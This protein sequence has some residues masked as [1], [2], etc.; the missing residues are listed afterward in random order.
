MVASAKVFGVERGPVQGIAPGAWVSVYKVCGAQGCFSSDTAAA[1]EQAIKDGV[2]VINFSI[3]G[4]TSPF[5]DPTELAFLDAY[6]A[7]VFVSASGGNDGP[8]VSTVNHLAPWVTTV[9]ASTQKREFDSTL[10]LTSGADSKVLVGAS[11]TDGVSTATPVVMSSAAPYNHQLCDAPAPPGKI[12]ACARGVNARVDK[13]FNVK[14]GGAVGMIL[15]NPTLADVETD[16]HWLPAV[17]LA[18]GTQFLAFISA[19]PAG[20]TATF[21]AGAKADGQADVLAA[22]S[23]RGPAGLFIKPDVTA[24][25]VEILAGNTPTPE[26]SEL[27][28]PGEY[29]MAIAGTSMAS[30]HIAGSGVLLKAL[31]PDWTPGQIKSALM[32]TAVTSVV[33]E[34]LTTAADPFDIG[35]GR[36]NLTVA[37]NPGLTFDETAENLAAI[38]ANPLK[39]V[40]ANLPSINAPVLPGTLTTSR[41]VKN[42]T[43][44][45]QTYKVSAKAPAGSTITVSPSSFTVAPGKTAKFSVTIKSLSPTAEQQFGEVR[46][47]PSRSGLPALHLPV[48]FVPQQGDVSLTSSCTP[49]SIK[50]LKN[51]TCSVTAANKSAL[52]T[53]VNLRTDTGLRTPITSASGADVSGLFTAKKDNVALSG[54]HPGIPSVAAGVS[55]GYLPLDL[56]GITP[57][58]IGDEQIL[59]FNIPAFSYNGRSYGTIGVDSNGYVVVGGGTAADNECCNLP[60]GASPDLPNNILAPFWTDLDGTGAPGIF[61]ASLTDGVNT[62]IVVEWRVNVF[63]TN[64]LQTFQLWLG[65]NGTQDV[66]YTYDP[67]NLP[68]A[69]GQPFLVVAENEVGQGGA[70]AGAPTEDLVVTSTP[71]SVGGTY[72]YTVKLLGLLPGTADVT[73]SMTTPIVRGTTV[74]KTPVT[75]TLK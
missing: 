24:P 59:N 38:E 46:L 36:V 35:S 2:K 11:I 30:P 20:V 40:D 64:S 69:G 47:T 14:A 57:Q 68:A 70:L 28:P 12:V 33:K 37:G 43:N 22:F 44:A 75:V 31:H 66:A 67:G 8:A 27:G 73:T 32:T 13:G 50:I 3:S 71:P 74:V 9:A 53:T 45:S 52:D 7:G 42:V 6:A 25:G 48:A 41:T 72:T 34:D 39:A 5:T 61:V 51:T 55:N 29:Y 4:G 10:T 54:S 56:F 65:V 60:A 19:H 63:G 18:D 15:Y 21:T 16:N 23:S 1:T 58:A 62:W 17:H 49:A 26:S